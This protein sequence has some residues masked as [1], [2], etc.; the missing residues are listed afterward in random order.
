MA[1]KTTG[2]SRNPQPPIF[3]PE[4]II[5][6]SDEEDTDD[7]GIVPRPQ[8]RISTTSSEALFD[9]FDDIDFN[10]DTLCGLLDRK[11][12]VNF[13]AG[14]ESDS[15]SGA[16]DESLILQAPLLD[17]GDAGDTGTKAAE[18]LSAVQQGKRKADVLSAPNTPHRHAVRRTGLTE[19]KSFS[20][21]KKA[22]QATQKLYPPTPLLPADPVVIAH[23]SVLQT[24]MNSRN[25]PYGVQYEIWRLIS[26][27]TIPIEA[28][29]VEVSVLDRLKQKGPTNVIAA[30]AT[31]AIILKRDIIPA[32]RFSDA[33]AR[34]RKAKSPWEALDEEE[35]AL[36]KDPYA[37]LGFR[38]PNYHGGKVHFEGKLKNR[39]VTAKDA[40][41]YAVGLERAE[42]GPSCRFSRRF[43]STRFLKIKIPDREL[44]RPDD[45]LFEYFLHPFVL[46]SGVFRAYYA[47]DDNVF[48]VKTNETYDHQRARVNQ[49]PSTQHD[50]SFLDFLKWHNPLEHNQNQ[51]MA[52][53]AAR[54]ALGLSNSIPG[55]ALE[56]DQILDIPDIVSEAGSDMTDGAGLINKVAISAI[57]AQVP[58]WQKMPVAL[59]CRIKG[60]KG[61]VVYDPDNISDTPHVSLR[62]SQ[63]KISY[64]S[65]EP[66]D[67]A[68]LVLDLLRASQARTPSRLSM[69]VIINL[70]ENGVP[71]FAFVNLIKQGLDRLMGPMTAWAH[72]EQTSDTMLD[73]WAA[74]CKQ[75]HVVAARL[76]REKAGEARVSGYQDRDPDVEEDED[77]VEL[78]R[79]LE[80][81]SSAWWADVISGCPSTLEETVMYLLE[82][83]FTPNAL[84]VLRDKLKDVL[85]PLIKRY[86]T[87]CRIEVPM[88][89]TAFLVPDPTGTLEPDEIFF[90]S[91]AMLETTSG[92]KMN[93]ILGD[94]LVVRNPCKLP[95]DAR[96]YRLVDN[97]ALRGHVDVIV[98]STKGSRRAADILAGGD[99]DGDKGLL[100]WDPELV[101]PFCNADLKYS[102]E[103]PDISVNFSRHNEKV[104]DF[105][106]EHAGDSESDLTAALQRYLLGALRDASIVGMYSNFH[107]VCVYEKGYEHPESI[108][109]AYMFCKSLDGAKTGLRVLEDVFKGD[110]LKYQRETPAWKQ[111]RENTSQHNERSLRRPSGLGPF[112]MEVILKHGKAEQDRC[113]QHIDRVFT[114]IT[115]FDQDLAVPWETACKLAKLY[116]EEEGS[117][118][119]QHDLDTIARHVEELYREHRQACRKDFT[120]MP[121]ETRQDTLRALSRKFSGK[122]IPGA[123]ILMDETEVAMLRASYAYIY[124]H[125]QSS[126]SWTRFPWDVAMRELCQIKARSLGCDHKTVTGS[127]HQRMLVKP[128]RRA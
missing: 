84:P 12:D 94:A 29:D 17:F 33:Y 23:S 31:A 90:K 27:D 85:K 109:L 77:N 122:P 113:L 22:T 106:E 58:A 61:L 95:T 19:S 21:S 36:R 93:Q 68:H 38:Q 100:I 54:F 57:Y 83:G 73:L 1:P 88:S 116:Q 55:C 98:M 69:E 115:T 107:D 71:A 9:E 125:Q 41:R 4:V 28:S 11:V 75:G 121:I 128:A 65:D 80:E 72:G 101:N 96:K 123:D 126:S 63:I 37:G 117:G 124:D 34:E 2:A 60:A 26:D 62:P 59:Q 44:S 3:L 120:N 67:P 43:G 39:A 56:A 7:I 127:F 24:C 14:E 104:S 35:A 70:A 86:I 52:K 119:R 13:D 32:E 112:I 10:D 91:S 97:P 15:Y 64:P 42:L 111:V 105:L 103:P 40:P 25:L 92:F 79:A 87:A 108:R 20:T 8:S 76:A 82:S 6:S 99:Y 102:E 118:R 48:L 50:L 78:D 110:R 46:G 47:K 45:E 81:R 66:P 18:P 53:W 16:G 30:P 5:I 74:V 114:K 89:A 51:T 49:H